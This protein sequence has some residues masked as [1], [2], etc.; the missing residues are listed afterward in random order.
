MSASDPNFQR[1]GWQFGL[2]VLLLPITYLI[3]EFLFHSFSTELQSL[4]QYGEL[5]HFLA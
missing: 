3:F 5:L 4:S 1:L 2:G